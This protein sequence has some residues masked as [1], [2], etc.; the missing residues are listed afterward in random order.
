MRLRSI[1]LG[2]AAA[3]VPPVVAQN[4]NNDDSTTSSTSSTSSTRSTTTDEETSTSTSNSPSSTTD[5]TKTTTASLPDVSQTSS[6]TSSSTSSITSSTTQQS[7]PPVTSDTGDTPALPTLPGSY[8]YPPPAVPPTKNAPFMQKSDLPQGTVFIAV[9]AIL[10]AFAVAILV[11]RAIV[12]CLLHRSVKRATLA[13]QVANDKKSYPP[14]AA[15]FYKYSDQASSVSLANAPTARAARKSRG[16]VPSST[17]SQSNLFFSPTAPAGSG[18]AANRESRFLPS[19]FYA[20]G[21][22]SPQQGHTHSISLTNLRPDSHGHAR[23]VEPSPPES[24]SLAPPQDTGRR[25][26]SSSSINLNRPPSGRAPS[27]FL[28]DLL[29]DQSEQFPP[30]GHRNTWNQPSDRF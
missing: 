3:L 14:P 20:S 22:A 21:A 18:G 5:S 6:S 24:P 7:V 4:N 9:G 2:L 26:I 10:G 23:A 30:A 15:P 11:W 12:A 28:E 13:Q 8:S 27:A 1:L 29:G 16:P 25:N 17:P 19:G